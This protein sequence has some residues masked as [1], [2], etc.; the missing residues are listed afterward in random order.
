MN[1]LDDV[2]DSLLIFPFGREPV[3]MTPAKIEKIMELE[4]RKQELLKDQQERLNRP[5]KEHGGWQN[6]L[7]TSNRKKSF[8]MLLQNAEK[9]QKEQA[10]LPKSPSRQRMVSSEYVK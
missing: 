8:D 2:A 6:N 7:H 3:N 9:R 4:A 5:E 1:K 10:A